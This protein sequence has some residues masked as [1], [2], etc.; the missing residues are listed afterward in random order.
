MPPLWPEETMFPS[1]RLVDEC[2]NIN[3]MEK[4]HLVGTKK[5]PPHKAS[6]TAAKC[7]RQTYSGIFLGK[8]GRRV[9]EKPIKEWFRG[10]VRLDY[11]EIIL[12][13]GMI[14]EA[15]LSGRVVED[16]CARAK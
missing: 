8:R 5:Q 2:D 14:V 12:P 3:T 10:S 7:R 15:E 11:N 13:D 1:A 4:Q 16:S 6:T 9:S